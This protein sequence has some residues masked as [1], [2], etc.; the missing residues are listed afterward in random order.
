VVF[1]P[2]PARAVGIMAVAI[3]IW[4]R[5]TAPAAARVVAAGLVAVGVSSCGGTDVRP[6]LAF[7]A[8]VVA[9]DNV[10]V[11]DGT[12][13]P[14]RDGQT[15]VIQADRIAAVGDRR[16][17][18][19]PAGAKVL[20]LAGR[21]VLPGFVGMHDH[22][23]YQVADLSA[24]PVQ[25]S[26]AMLYLAAG[27]T[28][29]RTGGA[30][31]FRGDR[32]IKG[33]I[34]EGQHPGPT[35]YLTSPYLYAVGDA[36]DGARV[37]NLIAGW[38]DDGATSFKAYAT[39]RRDELAAAIN[40]AHQRG[41]KVTGHL[42]AVGFRDAAALGIDNLEHGLLVDT[43]FYSEKV[44]DQCP[45]QSPALG[46]LRSLDIDGPQVRQ[47]IGLLVNR[48][49]AVTSTLAIYE[50]FAANADFDPRTLDVLTPALQERYRAEQAKRDDPNDDGPAA[51][52]S[53]L[54]KEMDFERAFVAAGGRLLA[55]SDP[56]GWGG[57][58]AGFGNQRQVELLVGSGF[59]AEQAIKIATANGAD[60]LQDENIG[61]IAPG[62]Q[63]D[64]IVVNG[65]PSTSIRDIR[66]VELVFR[67][68]LAYDSAR[69]IA[70]THGT[71]GRLDMGIYYRSPY[72]WGA[73]ALLAILLGR[74]LWRRFGPAKE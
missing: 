48:G 51:W 29:I 72:I 73:L 19:I 47:L 35:I 59:S 68:G 12:G 62:L 55:G 11:I 21:T 22:L 32:W 38:A 34:D 53:L 61:R 16:R 63:A 41:L 30:I 43:E 44:D 14:G 60:F 28:T 46:S 64:L 50:T 70:A 2:W 58:V 15:I 5:A 71:V 26:F 4:S 45:A 49:V 74:R 42:C 67:K 8:P 24:Y 40:A 66:N 9:L 20:D 36:S 13:Q 37:A 56:T 52:R 65:N 57:I 54:R 25:K 69:L 31:D 23:F 1:A 10:R 17:V 18:S 3:A 7:E 27:V 39:L 33:L 6:F